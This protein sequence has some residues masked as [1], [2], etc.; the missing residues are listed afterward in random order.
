MPRSTRRSGE[1]ALRRPPGPPGHARHLY[2]L[3]VAP[4]RDQAIR[5]LQALG[6]TCSVHYV[7]LH[8]HAF[9]QENAVNGRAAFPVADRIDAREIS[10]PIFSQMTDGDVGR[11]IDAVLQVCVARQDT[12]PQLVGA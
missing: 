9:W 2:P 10:L 4:G 6:V 5:Q 3:L 7:P 1:V 11:V 12:G 8:K